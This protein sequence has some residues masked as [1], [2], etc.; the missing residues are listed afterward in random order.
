MPRAKATVSESPKGD[1]FTIAEAL[2]M[3][4]KPTP[5][6]K[7]DFEKNVGRGV[8]TSVM[9]GVGQIVERGMAGVANSGGSSS[10]GEG[11]SLKKMLKML[12]KA[13]VIGEGGSGGGGRGESGMA[14]IV[15]AVIESNAATAKTMMEMQGKA[16]ERTSKLIEAMSKDQKETLRELRD[17]LKGNGNSATDMLAKIGIE[18]VQGSMQRDT[19]A[20]IAHAKKLIETVSGKPIGSSENTDLDREIALA[21]I[22]VEKD[23][24]ASEERRFDRELAS[25]SDLV[26]GALTALGNKRGERDEAGDVDFPR[27]KCGKCGEEFILK[28]PR[29]QSICPACGVL[30][31][32]SGKAATPP[33]EGQG[34]GEVGGQPEQTDEPQR[35]PTAE[36]TAETGEAVESP[37]EDFMLI[38]EGTPY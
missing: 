18:T 22:G 16:E 13:G 25:R 26:G 37:D 34:G 30:L 5:E 28:N 33:P 10:D 36:T 27:Y 35:Q 17:E 29:A 31:D 3:G 32:T 21:K 14:T 1:G 8:M 7:D 6:S 2:S 15:K 19:V 20:E 4:E 38:D 9:S 23:K 24:I 11:K 12:K